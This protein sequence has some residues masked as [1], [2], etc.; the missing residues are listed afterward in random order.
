MNSVVPPLSS[1]EALSPCWK[2]DS[3]SRPL[4]I[5]IQSCP[6]ALSICK[7]AYTN[8][9]TT[10]Y[11]ACPFS[12]LTPLLAKQ[13][14]FSVPSNSV[15][16]HCWGKKTTK[17]LLVLVRSR[18]KNNLVTLRERSFYHFVM[19]I[20]CFTLFHLYGAK[21]WSKGLLLWKKK[22]YLKFEAKNCS[23]FGKKNHIIIVSIGFW[24]NSGICLSKVSF[25]LYIYF[26]IKL[27]QTLIWLHTSKDIQFL[28]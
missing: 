2:N 20:V 14:Y 13:M 22:S 19:I 8:N 3:L 10:K 1:L 21:S 25:S 27:D 16:N 9:H 28:Q 6:N 18:H 5:G 15:T 23:S 11:V 26:Q 12:D 4:P 17:K 7:W 24:I